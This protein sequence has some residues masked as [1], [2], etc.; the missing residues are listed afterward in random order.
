MS[1]NEEHVSQILVAATIKAVP[2]HKRHSICVSS[3][4]GT[5][6]DCS[7]IRRRVS[8]PEENSR[9]EWDIAIIDLFFPL[10]QHP[11]FFLTQLPRNKTTV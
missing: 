2:L 8:C 1:P 7:P 10:E 3:P 9:M 6:E 5:Q 4:W 11:T